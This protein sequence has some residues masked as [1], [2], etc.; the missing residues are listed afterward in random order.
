MIRRDLADFYLPDEGTKFDR[1]IQAVLEYRS[2]GH[3]VLAVVSTIAETER[4]SMALHKAKVPHNVLNVNN[5]FWEASMIREAG[6]LDAVTVATAMAGRGTDIK[7]GRHMED[8]GGLAVVGIGRMA[9]ARMERQVRGRAGH[10]G[11]PGL[12]Q[13][14]VALTD[15]VVARNLPNLVEKYSA[16]DR[17]LSQRKLRRVIH[18]AQVLEEEYAARSRKTAMDY[19]QI[20]KKQRQL[21]YELR[22]QLLDGGTIPS[23]HILEIVGENV[24]RFLS[25]LDTVNSKRINRYILDNISYRT[26]GSTGVPALTDKEQAYTYLMERATESLNEKKQRIGVQT[27]MDSFVRIAAL[28]AIDDA[29]VEEVDYLQQLQSTVLGRSSA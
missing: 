3:P 16:G 14:F 26:E 28:A 15:E 6:K 1:A 12:S 4:V 25:S 9:S 24:Q 13:F 8:F 18:R 10:Q 21:V 29:W 5:V 2:L 20:L 11:D 27:G 19:D 22:N 7:L 17:R 23:E